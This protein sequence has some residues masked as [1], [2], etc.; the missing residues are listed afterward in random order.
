MRYCSVLVADDEETRGDKARQGAKVY[1]R[2]ARVVGDCHA[3][4]FEGSADGVEGDF[5]AVVVVAEMTEK[6]IGQAARRD[7]GEVGRSDSVV[8]MAAL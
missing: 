4:G 6:D 8:E 2:L 5:G 7:A 1:A 3:R